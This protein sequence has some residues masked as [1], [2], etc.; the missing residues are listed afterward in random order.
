[1]AKGVG[2]K[3]SREGGNEKIPKNSKK[4]GKMALLS[5]FQGGGQRKNRLK[6]SK[7]RP[8]NNIIKLLSTGGG[9]GEDTA[10]LLPTADAY[11]CGNFSKQVIKTTTTTT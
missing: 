1:V 9:G 10:P 5:L 3:I 2:R 7:K 4:T 6:N 8:K 11:V